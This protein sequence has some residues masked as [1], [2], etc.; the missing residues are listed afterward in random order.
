M[1]DAESTFENT[2]FGKYTFAE[3]TLSQKVHFQRK[4]TWYS[5]EIRPSQVGDISRACL[6]DTFV[7]VAVPVLKVAIIP[8]LKVTIIPVLKVA[9]DVL[10]VV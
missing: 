5:L 10:K 1:E 4:Y 2:F 6:G 7:A 3:S 9:I 8:V